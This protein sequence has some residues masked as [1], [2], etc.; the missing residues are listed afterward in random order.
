MAIKDFDAH[1]TKKVPTQVKFKTK[2]GDTVRFKADKPTRVKK[3][4]HFKTSDT[5]RG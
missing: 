4:V 1:E 3:H 2:D 5:K